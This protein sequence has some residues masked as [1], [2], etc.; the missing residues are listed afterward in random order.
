MLRDAV[1]AIDHPSA[2]RLA[3]QIDV[4]AT[5]LLAAPLY[6]GVRAVRVAADERQVLLDVW[7]KL[8]YLPG[9]SFAKLQHELLIGEQEDRGRRRLS[10]LV[11]LRLG[12]DHRHLA[13]LVDRYHVA[14]AGAVLA[15]A[16]PKRFAVAAHDDDRVRVGVSFNPE[17]LRDLRLKER[18]QCVLPLSER[19]DCSGHSA[20]L[21]SWASLETVLFARKTQR[22]PVRPSNDLDSTEDGRVSFG[23]MAH[24][25]HDG[26]ATPAARLSS[27]SPS[28]QSSQS[29]R[30]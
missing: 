6:A 16:A 1:L 12:G 21:S 4:A 2:V 23:V 22:W 20:F 27:V 18:I 9:G 13:A 15:E 17:A 11:S 14:A 24:V 26:P 10:G 19:I 25:V 30:T 7:R 3:T 8:E 5:M 29:T 28:A